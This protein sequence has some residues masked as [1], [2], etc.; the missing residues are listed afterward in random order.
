MLS[1]HD[2]T[3]VQIRPGLVLGVAA[4]APGAGACAGD[5]RL[6]PQPEPEL[7]AKEDLK[8]KVRRLVREQERRVQ[9]Q[10]DRQRTSWLDAEASTP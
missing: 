9:A 5:R 2:R 10:A 7:T 4:M 6:T 3:A 1:E 8:A